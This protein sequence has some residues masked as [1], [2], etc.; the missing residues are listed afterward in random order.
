MGRM[1][2]TPSFST[3]LVL[4]VTGHRNLDPNLLEP[5][6]TAVRGLFRQLHCDYPWTPIVLLSPLATGADCLVAEVALESASDVQLVAVLPW[7]RA[8]DAEIGTPEGERGCCEAL[9]NRALLIVDMP[10]PDHMSVETLRDTPSAR[11]N[12]FDEVG[13]YIA[14][15]CQILIAAWDGNAF[16]TDSQTA[17]VVR[18]HAEGAPAPFSV[19]AGALD[20]VDQ[21]AVCH[22]CVGRPAP[23]TGS[24]AATASSAA[25]NA[26]VTPHWE[27]PAI[28]Q[29]PTVRRRPRKWSKWIGW[30][31]RSALLGVHRLRFLFHPPHAPHDAPA[32]HLLKQ[33]WK[34]VDRYNQDVQ[35]MLQMSQ[36]AAILIQNRGY[37]VPDDLAGELPESV[38]NLRE[39]YARADTVAGH[40]QKRTWRMTFSLFAVALLAIASLETY[41]HLSHEPYW[42][43]SYLGLL[44][45]GYGLFRWTLRQHHQGRWLDYRALA[46]SLRVQA[47][48]RWA[49]LPDSVADHYLRHFRG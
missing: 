14:R 49:G 37:L 7:P 1:H 10:L 33:R 4:G 3:P 31:V 17:K 30:L 18:Y 40:W 35:Q 2:R 42:L 5:L 46:E 44:A 43:A 48:W 28:R 29:H 45:L 22:F 15:H 39:A 6:R 8:L 32:E 38:Y 9:I 47:F 27:W 21:T 11:E 36:T 20:T 34:M 26:V 41:S 13:R 23:A 25:G 19:R 24:P 16:A 12:Q